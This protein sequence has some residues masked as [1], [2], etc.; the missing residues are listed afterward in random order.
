[1]TRYTRFAFP[2]QVLLSLSLSSSPAQ[3]SPL[4]WGLFG[5]WN[6]GRVGEEVFV[7]DGMRLNL[8]IYLFLLIC[9]FV[10]FSVSCSGGC[11]FLE[12]PVDVFCAGERCF[13]LS[14]VD[15]TLAC[16]DANVTMA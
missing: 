14:P 7:W 6:F 15:L 1:M 4:V 13:F 2:C 9:V 10:R 8:F 11:A 5:D 16:G 12:S 3:L